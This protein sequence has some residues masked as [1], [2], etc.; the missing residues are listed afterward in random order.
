MLTV[1]IVFSRVFGLTLCLLMDQKPLE[2]KDGNVNCLESRYH[3]SNISSFQ[4]NITMHLFKRKNKSYLKKDRS[5]DKSSSNRRA[6]ISQ[7]LDAV[8]EDSS[9]CNFQ[10]ISWSHASRPDEDCTLLDEKPASDRG[11]AARR[12]AASS[13]KRT[14]M[15]MNP[16]PL[17]R[18]D[19]WADLGYDV[20]Q[21]DGD[22][23]NN[24]T[25][26]DSVPSQRHRSR[27]PSR[28][29]QGKTS[30][31]SS[32]SKKKGCDHHCSTSGSK[33][34]SSTANKKSSRSGSH[35]RRRTTMVEQEPDQ[36]KQSVSYHDRTRTS[37]IM[38]TM[39][40]QEEPDGS[41]PCKTVGSSSSSHHRRRRSSC[42]RET[43]KPAGG[44]LRTYQNFHM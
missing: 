31:S 30:S 24:G 21:L 36:T 43:Q 13:S 9:T 25:P 10:S 19:S 11:P 27:R 7:A 16:A 22:E 8:E 29:P 15:V 3:I 41:L 20:F 39:K 17:M 26:S 40:E 34:G 37:M 18:Q 23:T 6:L 32:S 38:T 33:N 44:R 4:A 28:R 35:H 5:A 14:T 42:S 1:V 2:A 12:S